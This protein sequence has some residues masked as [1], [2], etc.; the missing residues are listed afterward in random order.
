MYYRAH[1]KGDPVGANRGQFELLAI[2]F[3]H[4]TFV[5]KGNE[6]EPFLAIPIGLSFD[7]GES[8]RFTTLSFGCIFGKPASKLRFVT[9]FGIAVNHA[10]SY[11]GGGIAYYP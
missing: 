3:L 1:D 7:R 5:R 4:K 8:K 9:E 11:F 10:K 6:V 2:P